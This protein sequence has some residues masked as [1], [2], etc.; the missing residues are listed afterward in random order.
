LG[1][2]LMDCADDGLPLPCHIPQNGHDI[3]CHVRIQTTRGLISETKSGIRQYLTQQ[4]K[5]LSVSGFT[6]N[7]FASANTLL[8][9]ISRDM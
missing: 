3:L 5:T 8:H 7:R 6:A 9:L 1:G 4:L 2:R